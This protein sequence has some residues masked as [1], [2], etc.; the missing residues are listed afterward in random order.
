MYVSMYGCM[1]GC[2]CIA[3]WMYRCVDAWTDGCMDVL[4]Y[5]HKLVLLR[6]VIHTRSGSQISSTT[7]Q[8]DHTNTKT[9]MRDYDLHNRVAIWAGR[10]MVTQMSNCEGLR[11]IDRMHVQSDDGLTEHIACQINQCEIIEGINPP[12]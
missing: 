11:N 5:A 12:V 4:I 9:C 7:M 2:G 1:D 8:A 3:L 10:C 6:C